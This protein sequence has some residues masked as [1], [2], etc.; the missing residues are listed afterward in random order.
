M[1]EVL[2]ESERGPEIAYHLGQNPRLAREIARLSPLQAARELGRIEAKLAERPKAPAV[3]KAPPP[4]PTLAAT[5]PAVEKDP[6]KM[7]DKEWLEWRN[8][9]LRRANK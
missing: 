2:E 6:E 3:S 8:K 5:E 4:A 7:S 9:Q 1:L